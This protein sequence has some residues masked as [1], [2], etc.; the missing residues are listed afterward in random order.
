M[1]VAGG[2][3]LAKAV[4]CSSSRGVGARSMDCRSGSSC[5]LFRG[6]STVW[7]HA[8]GVCSSGE[9]EGDEVIA[10]DCVQADTGDSY[11]WRGW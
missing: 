11:R 3:L 7:L 10:S 2:A 4:G 5:F 8:A 6:L 9:G 1:G